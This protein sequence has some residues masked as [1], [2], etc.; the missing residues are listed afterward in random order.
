[1]KSSATKIVSRIFEAVLIVFLV[2]SAVFLW[3]KLLYI[4]STQR[5]IQ[6]QLSGIE[7]ALQNIKP[8]METESIQGSGGLVEEVSISLGIVS[9]GIAVFAIFGGVLSIFN[10]WRSKELEDAIDAT[11][12]AMENQSEL[13]SARLVQ[14]GRV[15]AMRNRNAYAAHSFKRAIKNAPEST[16][17]LIAEFE[18]IALQADTLPSRGGNAKE[19]EKKVTKL[20]EK[21]DKH[22]V[23]EGRLLRADAYFSLSCFFGNCAHAEPE[24]RLDYLEESEKYLKK[25]INCDKGNVD[26]Y[27]HLAVTCAMLGDIKKCQFNLD[28]A[29]SFSESQPLY[30]GLID[31]DRLSKLFEPSWPYLPV[32]VKEMLEEKYIGKPYSIQKA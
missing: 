3:E 22:R 29:R 32:K 30:A 1:M 11:K 12:K 9:S 31:S 19:L 26:F 13:T 6:T 20:V 25:A 17:A 27:R 28:M 21:L 15:Y 18:L 4:E 5:Q 7:E 16:A 10:I 14:E 24:K 8:H 23:P 2:A